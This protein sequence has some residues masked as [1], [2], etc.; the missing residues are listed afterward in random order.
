M[1][2]TPS[3]TT[4]YAALQGAFPGLMLACAARGARRAHHLGVGWAS[5][6]HSLGY[7]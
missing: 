5:K 3:T 1:P 6:G 4:P 2:G 7:S